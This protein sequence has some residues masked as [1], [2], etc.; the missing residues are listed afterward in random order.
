MWAKTP[1]LR[2]CALWTEE[3]GEAG[4]QGASDH[5]CSRPS[6]A[7]APSSRSGRALRRTGM[8][9]FL[10]LSD[11]HASL[12]LRQ[13][14]TLRGRA[15]TGRTHRTPTR[16]LSVS[17]RAVSGRPAPRWHETCGERGQ[18]AR[19]GLC[20]SRL[21]QRRGAYEGSRRQTE[22]HGSRALGEEGDIVCN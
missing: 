2:W 11:A 18:G 10:A 19:I 20:A 5:L 14:A 12:T 6:S 9:S 4:R 1:M 21:L 8:D 17:E 7:P 15:P 16:R 3:R 22:P 13:A